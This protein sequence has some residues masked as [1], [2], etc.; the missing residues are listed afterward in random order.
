VTNIGI[1][2]ISAYDPAA[3]TE[4]DAIV[5]MGS[6]SGVHSV[7]FHL[8]DD[9]QTLIIH[10]IKPFAY[11]ETVQVL[12]HALL[13]NSSVLTDSF[14]FRTMRR[15]ISGIPILTEL[16]GLQFVKSST[17]S[18][19]DTDTVLD[20][21][22][23]MTVTVDN[24]ATPGAIYFANFGGSKNNNFIFNIDEHGNILRDSNM[25]HTNILDF[26]VQPNGMITYGKF[27][28]QPWRW[29]GVDSAWNVVDS[30]LSTNGYN[31]DEHEL[32]VFSDSSY[33][34]LAVSVTT[35]DPSQWI[36][37]MDS[38]ASIGGDVIQIFDAHGNETFEWRGIDHYR[39]ADA[40]HENLTD[41]GIDFEHANSLDFDSAGN[42]I[43]SNRHLAEITKINRQTGA[44]MWRLGGAHNQFKLVGDSIWFSYQHDARWL[45]N[46]HMTI[47]DN[48][49][50]DSVTGQPGFIRQSR[51]LE[52]A[53][54]TNNMTATL[55]WQ[56]HHT[57]E[58]FTIA[59][60][61]VERLPNGNTLIGWGLND[62]TMTEVRPDNST[63]F[64]MTMGGGNWSYRAFKSP[65]TSLESVVRAPAVANSL[66]VNADATGTNISAHF[67]IER[68]E[69]VTLRLLDILGRELGPE[70]SSF[71]SVGEHSVE[72]QSQGLQ[73][74]TYYCEL[75]LADGSVMVRPFVVLQ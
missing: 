53:I 17:E 16:H 26:K 29:Y 1:S 54:D 24:G 21:L 7:Q 55:V 44:M 36:P 12:V 52:Y 69:A 31:V 42:I 37:G 9:R 13:A 6:R 14:Q 70:F 47:F 59:M 64:E 32:R 35:L 72:L 51:A 45:P 10:S 33:A 4:T 62:L 38:T 2:A 34:L 61:S 68:G 27:S 60:G 71:E 48:S 28:D 39:V 50:Y 43:L 22:P 73:S 19:L 11:D 41:S 15:A 23:P 5:A 66:T 30:F 75:R 8:S 57:P 20:T 18:L 56:W 49:D 67:A 46:G 74:G 3:L 25:V 40:I 58:T 65:D 63:A